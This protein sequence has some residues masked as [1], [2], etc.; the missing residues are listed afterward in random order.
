MNITTNKGL[1]CFFQSY[2]EDDI[3]PWLEERWEGKDKQESVLR[4]FARA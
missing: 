1:Y 3:R 4:L 2:E